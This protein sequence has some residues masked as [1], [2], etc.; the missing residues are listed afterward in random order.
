MGPSRRVVLC[1][2][3]MVMACVSASP[4]PAAAQEFLPTLHTLGYFPDP[5]ARSPR[6][7]GMGRL[8]YAS[9]VHNGLNAWDFAGNPLGVSSAESLSTIEYRPLV[10]TAASTHDLEGG[11]NQERQDLGARQVRNGLEAWRRAKD[12][13]SYGLLGDFTTFKVD[14][15]YTATTETRREFSVPAI[16]GIING[17]LS[18]IPGNRTM[19]AV[20][21]AYNL[22]VEDHNY[23]EFYEVP[24]GE[25]IGRRTE[26]VAGPD[27]FTPNHSEVSSIAGGVGLSYRI[28]NTI[29]AAAMVDHAK[30]NVKQRNLGLRS[31][32]HVTE[33]RP[34]DSGQL[35]INGTV[36]DHLSFVVDGIGFRSKSEQFFDWSI[37]AGPTQSPLAG[38]GK[39][40]D[41]DEEGNRLRTRAR[42]T[43]GALQL[44]AGFNTSYSRS[45]I[46]P[47]YPPA[48]GPI[49]GFN[50]FLDQIGFRTGADT[51]MLPARIVDTRVEARGREYG[52]GAS[53]HSPWHGALLGAEYHGWRERFDQPPFPGPEPTGW[54]LR[55]GGEV[56][57]SG[58]VLARA[59][60]VYGNQDLD[61][62][63]AANDYL[64]RALTAGLGFQPAGS[65]WS[66]DLAYAFAWVDPDFGD[67]TR[68]RGSR[69]EVA[70]QLRWPF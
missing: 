28:T 8:L 57:M 56:R 43:S 54:D 2:I 9:D 29:T 68:D 52:V 13:A 30:A 65:R 67:P 24:Q 10:R 63:T 50:D 25:Y 64:Q 32:S 38:S 40:L 46:T 26:Q 20:R 58:S 14:Q 60:F 19:Y 48:G 27:L 15:P 16:T 39:T 1:A 17:P 11:V 49:A 47:W 3:V 61:D 31:E 18:W 36:G 69:Q 33:E 4:G 7:A 51:L 22:E 34:I 62:L 37:S 59:G 21:I 70:L 12:G 35:T 23:F 66:A 5:L 44:D 45:I 55:L 41:R 42:W 53:W 6:L